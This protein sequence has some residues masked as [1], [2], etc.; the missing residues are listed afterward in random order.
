MKPL[1]AAMLI[2]LLCSCGTGTF[3][4]MDHGFGQE[5]TRQ[6]RIIN[7]SLQFTFPA[8]RRGGT[9]R[10]LFN[11]LYFQGD[12]LCFSFRF[13]HNVSAGTVSAE[14]IDP[15]TG[16]RF[17]AERLE[18]NGET[19][20]GFSLVGSLMENFKRTDLASPVPG[21]GYCCRDIPFAVE[22]SASGENGGTMT[23]RGNSSFTI[24]YR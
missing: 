9:A 1:A 23:A 22:V 14:F 10:D 21:D 7:T 19:V 5:V 15:A 17:D 20:W 13:S 18:V 11:F 8:Y 3:R 12:T 24:R 6:G 4:L 16:R 2:A